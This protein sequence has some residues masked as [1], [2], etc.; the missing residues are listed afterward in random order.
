MFSR[1]RNEDGRSHRRCWGELGKFADCSPRVP[2]L[3]RF[4]FAYAGAATSRYRASQLRR[5]KVGQFPRHLRHCP[6]RRRVVGEF[7]AIPREA[8]MARYLH[9][10]AWPKPAVRRA[11]F[12]KIAPAL[13][14]A[15]GRPAPGPLQGASDR[16]RQTSFSQW[17]RLLCSMYI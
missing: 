10:I 14:P 9:L 1:G 17:E 11:G 15:E 16:R 13:P 5:S 3:Q 7:G 4:H 6:T 8:L 2:L 12:W